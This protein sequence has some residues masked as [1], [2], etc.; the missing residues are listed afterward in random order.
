MMP[1]EY[2]RYTLNS[3]GDANWANIQNQL[4]KDMIDQIALNTAHREHR[5][6]ERSSSKPTKSVRKKD[7]IKDRLKAIN[8]R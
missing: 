4:L 8:R 2:K 3:P 1:I 6:D 7:V 5:E